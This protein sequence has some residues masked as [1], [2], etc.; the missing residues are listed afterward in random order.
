M[1]LVNFLGPWPRPPVRYFDNANWHYQGN[2]TAIYFNYK[3]YSQHWKASKIFCTS[4]LISFRNEELCLCTYSLCDFELGHFQTAIFHRA[5]S[6]VVSCRSICLGC[7]MLFAHPSS[8]WNLTA[9]QHIHP[10]LAKNTSLIPRTFWEV[11]MMV[12]WFHVL[13]KQT[14]SYYACNWSC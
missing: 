7:V 12:I 5:F 8:L 6:S 1:P 2:L 13:F 3:G 10:S 14:I 9:S 11:E 4:V